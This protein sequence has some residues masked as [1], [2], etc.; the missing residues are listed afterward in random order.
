MSSVTI[1]TKGFCGWSCR[2]KLHGTAVGLALICHVAASLMAATAFTA[3]WSKYILPG[4]VL[5]GFSVAA[6]LFVGRRRALLQLAEVER[7]SARKSAEADRL[8]VE[9]Q[10]SL[11][12]ITALLLDR[13]DAGR[14]SVAAIE[15]MSKMFGADS[16]IVW[17]SHPDRPDEL[18]QRGHAGVSDPSAETI[19]KANWDKSK[20]T[21]SEGRNK[22]VWLSD[23]QA[24]PQPLTK[25][26]CN[27]EQIRAGILTPISRRGELSGVLAVL[28]RREIDPRPTLE[29]ETFSVAQIIGGAVQGEELFRNL[30]QVQKV[31]SIG[32][33]TSGIAHDFNNVLA[34][35]LS[36][37]TYLKD[38]TPANSPTYRYLA[39]VEDSSKRGAALTKQL[40]AFARKEGPQVSVVNPN[41]VIE[42][43]LK[44]LERSF[45]KSILVQR[46]FARDLRHIEIDRSQLEQIILNIAVNA[47]DA[48]P[49]GGIFTITTRNTRLSASDPYR[50]KVSVP[51][52]EYVALSFRD[53]GCGMTEATIKRIFEPF[54]TTK[55]SGKG[56]GLGMSVVM[57]VVKSFGG[58]I[59]IESHPGK[60]T[61]F[62]VFLPSTD[63]LPHV[64]VE[65]KPADVRNGTEGIL[66][67]EDEEVIR[68]MAQLGLESKGYRVF[69]A[70][71]GAAAL[72]LYREH[73]D[74]IS[75][76]IADMVMPRI[77]GP[78][79]V[80]RLRDINP[81][82]RVVVSSGYSHDL[83]GKK[84]LENGCLGYVQKPYSTD[85]LHETIR[86]VLDS[87]L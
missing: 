40:L 63:K 50:P 41:E 57:S 75:L 38:R 74:E 56:T 67:A 44:L 69:A 32:T 23:A 45:D 24:I 64:E 79:L 51:D 10:T 80:T 5:V 85:K 16:V 1:P 47:R 81:D 65:T 60:G 22:A 87:G 83:E 14:M 71:D 66:I 8:A 86:S 19:A 84:M 82:V 42:Q 36:C 54:F 17:V 9:C 11:N 58:D 21:D 55:G 68:E 53:M 18:V 48:M 28:Y 29:A 15:E 73:A 72:A 6:E 46:Q 34:A 78:E 76:V 70:P 7:E 12:K 2:L 25:D 13:F 33:L 27:R 37:A 30:I 3:V 52:G 39:S 77:S 62:E 31:Q 43:T 26:F 49:G 59:R 20:F 35:I 61:L 4:L